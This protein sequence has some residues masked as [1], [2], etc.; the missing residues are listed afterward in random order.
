MSE[1]KLTDYFPPHVEPARDGMYQVLIKGN[2]MWS[3]WG[4]G[5]WHLA[6]SN[7][8][9]AKEAVIRSVECYQSGM[10]GWRGLAKQPKSAKAT[11][12]A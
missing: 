10:S 5:Q 12:P 11:R 7:Y 4:K 8:D 3:R 2:L 6:L 1:Q 9:R